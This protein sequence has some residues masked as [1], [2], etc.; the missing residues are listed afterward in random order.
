M[1]EHGIDY[2]GAGFNLTDAAKPS[3]LKMDG[4]RLG[5][6]ACAEHEFTIAT[7]HRPGANPF[8]PLESLDHIQ[9]L[10]S[11]CDHLVVL[12]HGGK[13]H[14]RYPSPYLRKVCRKMVEK[15]ASLVICQHSHCIGC[16]EEFEGAIIVYGQGN[17]LFDN[18]DSEYWQTSL[19]IKVDFRYGLDIEYIPIIKNKNVVRLATDEKAKEIL[20]AFHKRSTEILQ[21]GFIE[22]E[23]Q[24]FA[25]ENMWAYLRTL[26]GFGKWQSRID[27]Y[28]LKGALVKSKYGKN[29]LLAIQNYIECEAHRELVLAGLK[30]FL[31]RNKQ[32]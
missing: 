14:Y 18:S 30:S 24:K 7:E 26:S 28:L 16:F 2:V 17:F 9:E 20:K 5:V 23:Y 12:Y 1:E 15:G 29:Q 13:E 4:I 8:D 22:K 31:Q 3:I 10:K 27:R 21:E 19:L 32:V 11:K 6:Y 25:D